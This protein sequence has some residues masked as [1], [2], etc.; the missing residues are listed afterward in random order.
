MTKR[1][2]EWAVLAF[3]T[4]ALLWGAAMDRPDAQTALSP[5][6]SQAE[7]FFELN[8]TDDDLGIHASID[9][10]PW[11]A[12]EVEGPGERVLLNI[13]SRGRLRT[14]G[15]TQLSFE[16]A[17]P[18][19]AELD[20]AEFFRRFPEG[21]YEIEGRAQGGGS[22]EST[23]VLSHVLAAAPDNIL[24]SGLPAADSCDA[25]PL[26]TVSE[27]VTIDWDPVTH[28]HREIGKRG[29]IRVS[30]YQFFVEGE[31]VNLSLD[32]PPTVTEFEIPA[33]L[34]NAG[35]QYKFEI[36]VRT[37]TGN[38]TAVETCFRLQ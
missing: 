25:E 13:F 8:D 36:I 1:T 18:P 5:R 23:D 9:G 32:L 17:E 12:L 4:V 35:A 28:S 14:Q 11:M 29:P 22:I 24:V 26:P 27:P 7:L 21:R 10:G 30:R 38:N 31:G 3:I 20:P 33:A 16:S 34:T 37:T 6:F 19:F 15:M 2:K